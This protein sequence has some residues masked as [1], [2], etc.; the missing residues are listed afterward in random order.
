[1]YLP[2]IKYEREAAGRAVLAVTTSVASART[3]SETEQLAAS[4]TL[5]ATR[6]VDTA[7]PKTF[8]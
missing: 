4:A 8:E 6:Y 1:M 2:V 7:I 3:E 5:E